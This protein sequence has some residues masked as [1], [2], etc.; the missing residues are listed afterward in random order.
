MNAGSQ[1]ASRD[2]RRAVKGPLPSSTSLKSG[3]WA[4]WGSNWSTPV[5]ERMGAGRLAVT[6]YAEAPVMKACEE[7]WFRRALF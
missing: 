3:R 2:L 1:R 4:L 6:Q 7:H 5:G